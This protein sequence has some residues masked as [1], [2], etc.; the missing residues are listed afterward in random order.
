[1]LLLRLAT[2]PHPVATW[3]WSSTSPARR[4]HAADVVTSRSWSL[5][6]MA[7]PWAAAA[8]EIDDELGD[9]QSI[10]DRS[11]GRPDDGHG[12]PRHAVGTGLSGLTHP[13]QPWLTY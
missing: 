4:L 3:L 6:V 13:A 5:A 8:A 2:A 10:A 11:D 1:M 12:G 7:S 9:G